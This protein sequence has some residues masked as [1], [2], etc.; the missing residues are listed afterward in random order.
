MEGGFKDSPLRLNKGLGQL[1]EWNAKRIEER[2]E[3]LSAKALAIWPRPSLPA[4]TLAEFHEP[5]PETEFTIEDHPQL[6]PPVRRAL[7]DK[8]RAEVLSFD[9][10]V[11]EQFLKLYVAYKSETNFVDVVPQVA[12]LRLSL[13]LPFE[14][15][16]DERNLAWDVTGRGHWGNGNTEVGLDEN[17]DF[18]YVMGLVRQ[19]YEFQI[20]D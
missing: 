20:A 10:A 8:F 1:D 3:R 16:H 11:T 19:A 5:R 18:T 6:L 2:A 13:N 15:L 4:D 14:V 12:R 7:F 17:S 9:P